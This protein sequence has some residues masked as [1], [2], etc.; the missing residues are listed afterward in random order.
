[1]GPS[2]GVPD[3]VGG[4][5]S[6]V[7]QHGRVYV[8]TGKSVDVFAP[9]GKILGTIP[10][11]QGLHGTF[12]GVPTRRRSSLS[13]LMADGERPALETASSR[14]QPSRKGYTGRAK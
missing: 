11:P 5:G 12:F 10:G 1:M 8:A 4:D 3:G 13:C 7:D 2:K 14:F 9:D 6:A